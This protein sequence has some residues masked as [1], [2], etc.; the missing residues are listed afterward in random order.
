M[1]PKQQILFFLLIWFFFISAPSVWPQPAETTETGNASPSRDAQLAQELTNPITDLITIPIQMN[2][3][4][5]IGPL[6]DGWKLQ[7]NIQPVIPFNRV[8]KNKNQAVR[9]GAR[10]SDKRSI[11]KHM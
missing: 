1:K 2:Y 11:F 8:L 5:D 6:D 4:R 7:T 9:Q 3:D 10:R